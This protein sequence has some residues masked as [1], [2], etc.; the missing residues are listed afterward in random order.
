MSKELF[1]TQIECQNRILTVKI[2]FSATQFE[3]QNRIFN[4]KI[5][6]SDSFRMSNYDFECQNTILR[7]SLNVKLRF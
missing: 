2:A 4:V 3:C 5:A 7:L 6:F 1:T